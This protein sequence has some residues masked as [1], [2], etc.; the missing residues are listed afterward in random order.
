MV[1]NWPEGVVS[2][3]KSNFR[4]SPDKHVYH[5]NYFEQAETYRM[6]EKS[7]SLD[8]DATIEGLYICQ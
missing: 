2:D 5:L 4:Y 3:D 1:V 8:L 7:F 6:F